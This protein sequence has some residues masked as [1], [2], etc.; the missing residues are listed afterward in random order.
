MATALAVVVVVVAQYASVVVENEFEE[1]EEDQVYVY[2]RM[3]T[4]AYNIT[5]LLLVRSMLLELMQ[6]LHLLHT[7]LHQI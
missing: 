6:F 3:K 7:R 5:Y 1:W 2:A 4:A